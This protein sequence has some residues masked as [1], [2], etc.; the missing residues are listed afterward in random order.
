MA[1]HVLSDGK[2]KLIT[3]YNDFF[4]MQLKLNHSATV[5]QIN[6]S[7][8]TDFRALLF[9]FW[10]NEEVSR[11]LQT[12]ILASV[13]CN[14]RMKSCC[15]RSLSVVDDLVDTPEST[16]ARRALEP[17][18]AVILMAIAHQSLAQRNADRW[19]LYSLITNCASV[20]S[21]R[22]GCHC[23]SIRRFQLRHNRCSSTLVLLCSPVHN[24]HV[25]LYTACVQ[26]S[27]WAV[28]PL[29]NTLT[30]GR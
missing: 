14:L 29:R 1:L 7:N 22:R 16:V 30:T 5:H 6:Y 2:S 11:W 15:N 10:N 28:L 18:Y 8:E 19:P 3:P 27:V 12:N 4:W 24:K 9:I 17:V 23:P 21:C 25:I 13:P 26:N 20:L